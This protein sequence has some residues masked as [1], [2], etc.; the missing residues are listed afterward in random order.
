[1]QEIIAY[2]LHH[3]QRHK[4]GHKTLLEIMWTSWTS[5]PPVVRCYSHHR[6]SYHDGSSSVA[7]AYAFELLTPPKSRHDPQMSSCGQRHLAISQVTPHNTQSAHPAW[8]TT[9]P[10]CGTKPPVGFTPRRAWYWWRRRV[11]FLSSATLGRMCLSGIQ[12]ANTVMYTTARQVGFS[13]TVWARQRSSGP[14]C[15]SEDISH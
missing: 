4:A 9:S 7:E 14:R 10:R 2:C 1:M 6:L 3:F 13:I 15:Q 12:G 11:G 8:L 5:C